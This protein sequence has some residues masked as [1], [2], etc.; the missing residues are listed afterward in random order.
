[1]QATDS[2]TIQEQP[3]RPPLAA[4]DQTTSGTLDS[5]TVSYADRINITQSSPRTLTWVVEQIRA[6]ESLRAFI[7]SLRAI[8]EQR[9]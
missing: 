1:M 9:E 7:A 6:S 4:N 5:I 8:P 3:S 2:A